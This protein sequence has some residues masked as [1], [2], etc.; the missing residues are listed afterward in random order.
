MKS[1]GATIPP[2][3]MKRVA[4]QMKRGAKKGF[5][6]VNF[7]GDV[8]SLFG[9]VGRK[10][11]MHAGR[12]FRAIT[13]IGDY[14]IG[15]NSVLKTDSLPQFL[16]GRRGTIIAH[17]E[18]LGDVITSPTAA[19]FKITTFPIQPALL[20]TFPWLANIAENYDEY[21]IEGMVFEF[22]SNSSN[23]L[24]SINTA[25][26][27][28]IM[29]TQYNVLAPPFTNK[30]QM[31]QYEFT[32]T[33]KPSVSF[34]HPIECARI[35]TPTSV[36][37]T[38]N[39]SAPG[40]LRL[41][42]WGNFNIATVGQQGTSVNIGE[43]WVTYD[44]KLMKPKQGAIVDVQDHYKTLD[45]ALLGTIRQGGPSYFGIVGS[46][47]TL[48]TTSD[49]GTFLSASPL[50]GTNLDTINFPSTYYGNVSITIC[51]Y[52]IPVVTLGSVPNLPVTYTY[53]VAGGLATPLNIVSVGYNNLLGPTGTTMV[54]N[55]QNG[56]SLVLY[57]NIAGGGSVTLHGG[58][59]TPTLQGL[60]IFVVALP[61]PI[62]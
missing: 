48:S 17:R 32:C 25:L 51:W 22:K 23:A 4:K 1:K 28:V 34:L 15:K 9:P 33:A 38:R 40:D 18:Y 46:E 36:L 21:T 12:M 6:S 57:L 20:G 5:N 19:L 41:Y 11:G 50:N 54:E 42:D 49:L 31:E 3:A 24:N 45:P 60:D 16:N 13:G 52:V 2:K 30:L 39:G 27:T 56:A 26:G 29:T 10:L 58:T 37:S 14:K 47:P 53:N 8:G 59:T 62:N 35:E 44:I 61:T 7:G 43:L 55:T